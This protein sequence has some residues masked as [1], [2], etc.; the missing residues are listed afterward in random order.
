M[1]KFIIG[2]FKK[3]GIPEGTSKHEDY[4]KCLTILQKI[5]KLTASRYQE[6]QKVIKQY[7]GWKG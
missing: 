6:G 5:G 2:Q 3:A 7:V 1:D 4:Q